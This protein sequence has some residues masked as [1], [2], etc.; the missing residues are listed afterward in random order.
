MNIGKKNMDDKL[1]IEI[2][3]IVE[4]L[5]K[6]SSDLVTINPP[7]NS[8]FVS[9]FENEFQVKLPNDYKYLLTKTNGFGLMGDD[10]LGITFTTYGTD[11]VDTYKFE[12][13]DCIVP[14]YNYLVPFCP[15]GGGNF[16]CFDTKQITKDGNSCKII[17]WVSNY[18]YSELDPP[19]VS[20]ECLADFINECIIGWTLEDYNYD[21]S[22]K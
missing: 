14:Q 19:E 3:E 11:L 18:E 7:V 21:G 1:K 12:H 10:V 5:A 13:Y 4:E 17:F 22:N 8:A 2:D 16:Y 15:D 6:F 20:H 9:K